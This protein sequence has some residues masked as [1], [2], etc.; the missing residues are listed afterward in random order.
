MA[1]INIRTHDDMRFAEWRLVARLA[2][3]SAVIGGVDTQ[4]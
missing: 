1:E 4:A 3:T 2:K